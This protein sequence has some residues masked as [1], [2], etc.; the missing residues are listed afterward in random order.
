ML[1]EHED[2]LITSFTEILQND[3]F[4]LWMASLNAPP[5]LQRPLS[6]G[7]IYIT[8]RAQYWG[9]LKQA[10]LLQKVFKVGAD[11]LAEEI[12]G[13]CQLVKRSGITSYV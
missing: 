7:D 1:H 9:F 12:L 4:P 11:A 8:F 6:C 10:P 13:P 3:V 2:S 5:A